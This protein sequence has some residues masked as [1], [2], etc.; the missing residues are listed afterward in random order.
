MIWI[1]VMSISYTHTHI[2][3]Y[4]SIDTGY[5]NVHAIDVTSF[6]TSES[7]KL[8]A[9]FK[10]NRVGLNYIQGR[11]SQWNIITADALAPR[12]VR[13]WAA[14]IHAVLCYGVFSFRSKDFNN[15]HLSDIEKSFQYILKWFHHSKV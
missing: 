2:Y 10:L 8:T 11:L 9:R 12:A 1:H 14:T 15:I 4:N 7:L 13:S 5:K 6:V 3:I